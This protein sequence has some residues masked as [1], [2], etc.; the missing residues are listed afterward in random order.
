[1]PATRH[2]A[3]N[4]GPDDQ[5]CIRCCEI[6]S[7]R[8][9]GGKPQWPGSYFVAVANQTF[10]NHPGAEDCKLVAEDQPDYDLAMEHA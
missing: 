8:K 3:G 4:P 1:M 9:A 7:A 5:R 10:T 2:V 6:I